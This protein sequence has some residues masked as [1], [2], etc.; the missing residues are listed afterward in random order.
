MVELD[1]QARSTAVDL[2]NLLVVDLHSYHVHAYILHTTSST[3]VYMLL[4][5]SVVLVVVVANLVQL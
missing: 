4:Y 5:D 1:L 3:A 2:L